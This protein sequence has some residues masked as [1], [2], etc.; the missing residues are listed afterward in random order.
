MVAIFLDLFGG[1]V[2]ARFMPNLALVILS[3]LVL[4]ATASIG[5]AYL[6]Y[7]V[8]G[9]VFTENEIAVRAVTGLIW[10]PLIT[11]AAALF[12]RRQLRKKKAQISDAL[13]GTV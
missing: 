3:A 10:H 6:I 13:S 9:D 5:S 4:G 12:Y 2:S 7:L 11:I 1:W 8:G